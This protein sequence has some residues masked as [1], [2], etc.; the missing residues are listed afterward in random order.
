MLLLLLS[1]FQVILSRCFDLKR[2]DTVFSFVTRAVGLGLREILFSWHEWA[3]WFC[4]SGEF[5]SSPLLFSKC[6]E[7][8]PPA[9]RAVSNIVDHAPRRK[10]NLESVLIAAPYRAIPKRKLRQVMIQHLFPIRSSVLF[11]F[12]FRLRIE[13]TE[14]GRPG[15]SEAC[16]PAPKRHMEA[17]ATLP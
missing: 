2:S 17:S 9:L 10:Q 3:A 13:S 11:S 1:S 12:C 4:I 7:W 5:L 14:E 16:V 15:S 6:C 8:I